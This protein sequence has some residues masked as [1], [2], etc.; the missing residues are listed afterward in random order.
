M[1]DRTPMM[2]RTPEQEEIDAQYNQMCIAVDRLSEEIQ[3]FRAL[4]EPTDV[5]LL[6]FAESLHDM[7]M[8]VDAELEE[9]R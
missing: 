4:Y 9:N 6:Q 7:L 5:S 1:T 3:K 2:N 8:E